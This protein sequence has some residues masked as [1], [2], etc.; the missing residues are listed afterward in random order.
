MSENRRLGTIAISAELLAAAMGFPEGTK[1]RNA[2][3]ESWGAS[4]DGGKIV[5]MAHHPDFEPVPPDAKLPEIDVKYEVD[6][7]KRPATWD[8]LEITWDLT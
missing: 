7:D 6:M 8:W 1:I 3:W 5:L 4:L 2:W